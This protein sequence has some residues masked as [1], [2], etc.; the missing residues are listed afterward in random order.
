MEL[1]Q[2]LDIISQNY[3]GSGV[4][5]ALEA[6]MSLQDVY[7]IHTG[8]HLCDY[9]NGKMYFNLE[10]DVIIIQLPMCYNHDLSFLH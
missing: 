1:L 9:F 3:T 7:S 5:R 2:I 4:G 10:H 8:D 6:V